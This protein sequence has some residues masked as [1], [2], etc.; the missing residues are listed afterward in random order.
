MGT[1]GLEREA[2]AH[3]LHNAHIMEEHKIGVGSALVWDSLVKGMR[4]QG[5][6]QVQ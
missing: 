2:R 3:G 6:T 4:R 5:V 1:L